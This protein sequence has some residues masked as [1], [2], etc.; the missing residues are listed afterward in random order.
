MHAWYTHR[1]PPR[2]CNLP[3]SPTLYLSS[4]ANVWPHSPGYVLNLAFHPKSFTDDNIGTVLDAVAAS[5]AANNTVVAL[6][7]DHGWQLG[8]HGAWCKQTMWEIA[9]RGALMIS[10]PT[11]R[12]ASRVTGALVEFV[13]IYPTLA[14]LSGLAVPG[15]CPVAG[16]DLVTACTDGVSLKP[17][18]ASPA[19]EL[20]PAALSLYPRPSMNQIQSMGYSMV[21]RVAG[22]EYRYTEWVKIRLEDAG[23]QVYTKLWAQNLGTELYNHSASGFGWSDLENVNI[24]AT[25]PALVATFSATLRALWA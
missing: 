9:T 15:P 3:D 16:A 11:L 5:S 25:H 13:D 1:S 4:T 21:I 6:W 19:A 2:G 8:E 12:P 10:S 18:W 24:A 22:A 23:S 20:H 14:D 7:G 17:L